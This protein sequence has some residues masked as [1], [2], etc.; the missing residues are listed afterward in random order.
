MLNSLP[1]ADL[2]FLMFLPTTLRSTKAR[3]KNNFPKFSCWT[4]YWIRER[5]YWLMSRQTNLICDSAHTVHPAAGIMSLSS[6]NEKVRMDSPYHLAQKKAHLNGK[7]IVFIICKCWMKAVAMVTAIGGWSLVWGQRGYRNKVAPN[8]EIV[9]MALWESY[10]VYCWHFHVGQ[11]SRS[12]TNDQ[13]HII[14]RCQRR[15]WLMKQDKSHQEICYSTAQTAEY[16]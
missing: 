9:Q 15:L 16:S 5:R 2:Y 6:F 10:T 8:G 11:Q 13:F 12:A 4:W 14:P 7:H 3:K 1:E